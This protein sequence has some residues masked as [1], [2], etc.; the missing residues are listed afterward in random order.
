VFVGI[1]QMR[2]WLAWIGYGQKARWAYVD[3]KN[4]ID[5]VL[6]GLRLGDFPA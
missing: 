2:F 3:L 1:A 6:K 5:D 4:N